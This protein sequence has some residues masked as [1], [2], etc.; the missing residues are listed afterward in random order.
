MNFPNLTYRAVA[1]FEQIWPGLYIYA[2]TRN[3]IARFMGNANQVL[4]TAP[5][6]VQRDRNYTMYLLNWNRES[7]DTIKVLIVE[8]M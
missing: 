3:T 8:D 5:L 1:E 6:Q 2:V 4:L 7:R